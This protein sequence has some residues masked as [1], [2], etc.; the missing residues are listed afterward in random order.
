MSLQFCD[1]HTVA[2]GFGGDGLQIDTTN[3]DRI[4]EILRQAQ[5]DAA[6]GRSVLLNCL[7]GKTSFREG[8]IS[9]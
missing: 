7:I 1:Y 5:S 6:N 8:S 2:K 3:E 4:C 9:V